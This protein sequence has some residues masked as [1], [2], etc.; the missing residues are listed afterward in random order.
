M[1]GHSRLF[2]VEYFLLSVALLLVAGLGT[3]V[4]H[5]IKNPSPF[6]IDV[7]NLAV[8]VFNWL[9]FLLTP[10]IGLKAGQRG[11]YFGGWIVAILLGYVIFGGGLPLHAYRGSR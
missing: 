5:R 2:V 1:D 3:W 7:K 11:R 6:A 4:W 9:F 10:V 8:W